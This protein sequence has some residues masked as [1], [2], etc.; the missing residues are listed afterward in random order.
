M[1]YE[2]RTKHDGEWSNEV[3]EP[4]VFGSVGEAE[5]AIAALKTLGEDWLEAE[6][7]VREIQEEEL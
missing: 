2:V 5:R 4:N 1:K 3:G 6:Y 7:R